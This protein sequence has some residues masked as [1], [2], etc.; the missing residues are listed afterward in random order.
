MVVEVMR[1]EMRPSPVRNTA[2]DVFHANDQFNDVGNGFYSEREH[3]GKL[4]DGPG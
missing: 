3:G 2:P 1:S 4:A